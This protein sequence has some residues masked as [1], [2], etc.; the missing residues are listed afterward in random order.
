MIGSDKEGEREGE[1][2]AKHPFIVDRYQHRRAKPARSTEDRVG[3]I[4]G[5]ASLFCN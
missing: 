3:N 1:A 4:A 5:H 2:C